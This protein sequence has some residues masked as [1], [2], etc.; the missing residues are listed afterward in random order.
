M[1]RK[2]SYKNLDRWRETARKQCRR[3]YKRTELASNRSKPWDKT[4]L[5]IVMRHELT[6]HEISKEI[7]RSVMAIQI[8]R[9]REKKRRQERE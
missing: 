1:L 4:E 2:N 8:A 6:D 7:G 3:Y 5:D 9:C